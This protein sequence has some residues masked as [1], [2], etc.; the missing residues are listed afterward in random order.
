MIRHPSNDNKREE[1]HTTE[2]V[3]DTRNNEFDR[4]ERNNEVRLVEWKRVNV[5]VVQVCFR[6][7]L[8]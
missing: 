3:M 5:Y 8:R 6:Q 2:G 7:S 1:K 4:S